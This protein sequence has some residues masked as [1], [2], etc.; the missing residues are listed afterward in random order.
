MVAQRMMEF[1]VNYCAGGP[2]DDNGIGGSAN[3]GGPI[4]AEG[5]RME[6]SRRQ[7]HVSS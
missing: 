6:V 1:S 5:Y 3:V 2:R 4:S 7:T